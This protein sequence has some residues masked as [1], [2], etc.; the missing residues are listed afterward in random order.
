MLSSILK[1]VFLSQLIILSLEALTQFSN[2]KIYPNEVKI[3]QEQHMY[4][5]NR[6]TQSY[7]MQM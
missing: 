2:C 7:F 6:Q 5:K 1:L 4:Q 3:K